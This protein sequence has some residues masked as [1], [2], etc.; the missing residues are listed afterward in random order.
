MLRKLI[1]ACVGLAMMGMAGT[2]N[3]IS[4]GSFTFDQTAFADAVGTTT[5]TITTFVTVAPATFPTRLWTHKRG[6]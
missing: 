6:L 1:G 4:I 2:A 5:G 3:A